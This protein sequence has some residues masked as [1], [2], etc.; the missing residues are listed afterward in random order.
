[1]GAWEILAKTA[2]TCCPCMGAFSSAA[3][4]RYPSKAQNEC[5]RRR[6][7]ARSNHVK[8]QKPV[9]GRIR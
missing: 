9:G 2:T 3:A 8:Y 6:Y 7:L 4:D 5:L 1:M